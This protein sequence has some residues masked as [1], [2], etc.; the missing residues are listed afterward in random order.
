MFIHP[1]ED[2]DFVLT[3]D[4]TVLP[5][6]MHNINVDPDLLTRRGGGKYANKTH[7]DDAAVKTLPGFDPAWMYVCDLQ[8]CWRSVFSFPF[9]FPFPVS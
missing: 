4:P 6:Y 1:T 2:Y 8:V 7:E 9:L 3:L 5:R